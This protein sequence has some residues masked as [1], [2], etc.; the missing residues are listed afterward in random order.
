MLP[1]F[2]DNGNSVDISIVDNSNIVSFPTTQTNSELSSNKDVAIWMR[3]LRQLGLSRLFANLSDCRQQSKITY[4]NL[5][6]TLWAFAVA[7]FR[8]GSKNAL[9]TTCDAMNK[10]NRSSIANFLEIENLNNLPHSKTVDNYLRHLNPDELNTV[11]FEIFSWGH[12]SKL[13]YNH[14]EYLSPDNNYL[15]GC[16]GFWTHTYTTPHAIDEYGKNSC[17]YCLPRTRH[18]G[19]PQE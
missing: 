12:K 10:K 19:T 16:D 14:S 17:P 9:N 18:A 8:Q 7:T 11:L 2:V 15:L 5:S 1:K 4:S 13:F 3:F 6:L